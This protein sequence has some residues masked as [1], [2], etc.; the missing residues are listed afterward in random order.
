MTTDMNET[1]EEALRRLRDVGATGT[2]TV[3][4]EKGTVKQCEFNH[5]W[6]P[7]TGHD[8]P[9]DLSESVSNRSAAGGLR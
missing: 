1:P 8:E 3:H 4:I 6:R 9:V 7:R 2:L 5:R